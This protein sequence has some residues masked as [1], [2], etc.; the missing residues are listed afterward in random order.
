[1]S[2][3]STSV[4][5]VIAGGGPAGMILGLL[6]ARRGV[7]V[8]VLESHSDFERDFRGDTIHPATM[9][10]LDSIGL[11]DELL[12]LENAMVGVQLAALAKRDRVQPTLGPGQLH[13]VSEAEG[14]AGN[15]DASGSGTVT[16][17]TLHAE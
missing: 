13:A 3:G 9:E 12:V 15:A 11:A 8:Q 5:C 1:M 4:Q 14:A 6:L 2:E 7:R 16:R 10:M 17:I